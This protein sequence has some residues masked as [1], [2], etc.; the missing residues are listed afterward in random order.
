MSPD[1]NE[2]G[3]E[4]GLDQPELMSPIVGKCFILTLLSVNFA[5]WPRIYI[6]NLNFL[7]F[8][9]DTERLTAVTPRGTHILRH[10]WICGSNGLLFYKKSVNMDPKIWVF[11]L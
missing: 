10:T 8:C 7:L 1:L 2:S 6:G 3:L 9:E 4:S 5:E 11:A